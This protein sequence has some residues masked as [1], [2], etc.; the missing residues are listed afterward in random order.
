MKKAGRVLLVLLVCV[1]LVC[2]LVTTASGTSDIYFM[3]VN[4]TLVPMTAE[5]MPILV[6]DTLYVPYIMFALN[7]N[8]GVNLGVTAQYSTTRRTVMVSQGSNVVIFDPVANTSYDL[9]GNELDGRAVL[10]NAMAYIP[11]D[12]ICEYFDDIR[13]SSVRMV[14]GTLIRVTNQMAAMSD[15]GFVS[16]ASGMLK[17]NYR[18]YLD[19]ITAPSG[20]PTDAPAI[21]PRPE[22][23]ALVY[24]AFLNGSRTEEMAQILENHG[25]QGLFFLT[26]EELSREDELVRRLVG[27]GH[28]VG[29]DLT[30]SDAASCLLQAAEGRQLLAASARCQLTVVRLEGADDAVRGLLKEQG[31]ALWQASSRVSV[32][33]SARSLLRSLDSERPN[34]VEALCEDGYVSLLAEAM[35]ELTGSGYRLRPAVAPAL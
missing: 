3:A 31:Y 10:R 29:L 30:G 26:V 17:N 27:G 11:L 16:A 20:R 5:N 6:G 7:H 32:E 24:L 8:G 23:G 13:Y 9:D 18:D 14:Y 28:L 12:W 1:A 35:P 25:R 19:S 21:T 2:G 15:A 33:E 34:Y 22:S 4:E